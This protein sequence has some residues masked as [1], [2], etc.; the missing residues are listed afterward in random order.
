[1]RASARAIANTLI[2]FSSKLALTLTLSLPA[3]THTLSL[4]LWVAFLFLRQKDASFRVKFGFFSNFN[5]LCVKCPIRLL[6][7]LLMPYTTL[8]RKVWI[9]VTFFKDIYTGTY[10]KVTY[11]LVTYNL[12]SLYEVLIFEKNIM[13]TP[14]VFGKIASDKNFTDR[15]NETDRLVSNFQSSVNTILISPRRWGKSW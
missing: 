6:Y 7:Q 9:D 5:R 10:H 12:V 14:F 13:E 1:M 4:S 3:L 15:K 11:I 8:H 2:S